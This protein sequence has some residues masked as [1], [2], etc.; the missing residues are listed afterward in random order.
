MNSRGNSIQASEHSVLTYGYRGGHAEQC[1]H[2]PE[3]LLSHPMGNASDEVKVQASA[4]TGSNEME[5]FATAVRKFV[6]RPAGACPG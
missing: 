6:L 4:V 2:G 3:K 1:P 5:A